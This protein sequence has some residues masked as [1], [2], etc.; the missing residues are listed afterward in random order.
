MFK[1]FLPVLLLFFIARPLTA[2][3]VR[4]EVAS[5]KDVLNGKPFGNAQLVI[6]RSL[7]AEGELALAADWLD[8]AEE[9]FEALGS[10]SHLAAAWVARGDLARETGD[11]ETAADVYRRAADLLQDVHL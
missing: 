6:A 10:T 1:R 8:A 11:V 9:T 3:V 5:R 4:V 2:E 7:V